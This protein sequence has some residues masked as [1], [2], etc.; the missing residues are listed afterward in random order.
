MSL[1]SQLVASIAARL[2][3]FKAG[4]VYNSVLY[5]WFLGALEGKGV[6]RGSSLLPSTWTESLASAPGIASC[7]TSIL[8]LWM[9]RECPGKLSLSWPSHLS[10]V[11]PHHTKI[12]AEKHLEH[13]FPEWQCGPSLHISVQTNKYVSAYIAFGMI[14]AGEARGQSLNTCI[15]WL[16]E[17]GIIIMPITAGEIEAQMDGLTCSRVSMVQLGLWVNVPLILSL[18]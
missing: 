15:F 1:V 10:H 6:R 16:W 2:G 4:V 14:E 3:V 12:T 9:E 8:T 11:E 7:L 17:V 5:P 18:L 13:L